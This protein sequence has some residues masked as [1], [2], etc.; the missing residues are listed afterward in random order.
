MPSRYDGILGKIKLIPEEGNISL[1]SGTSKQG[2][3]QGKKP[4][5]GQLLIYSLFSYSDLI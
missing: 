5:V 3:G 2:Q 1:R 4:Q